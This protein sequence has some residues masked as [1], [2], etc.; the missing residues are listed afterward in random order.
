MPSAMMM[1]KAGVFNSR[2]C[3]HSQTTRRVLAIA[4]A[5]PGTTTS[6]APATQDEQVKV[7]MDPP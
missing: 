6:A 7:S 3:L 4:R 1:R 2:A 5:E